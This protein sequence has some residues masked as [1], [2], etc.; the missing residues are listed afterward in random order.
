MNA[1][2]ALGSGK[3]S[4]GK[5]RVHGYLSLYGKETA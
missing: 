1:G 3:T 2:G 5:G 4:Y